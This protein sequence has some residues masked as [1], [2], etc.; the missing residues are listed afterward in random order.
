[1]RPTYLDYPISLKYHIFIINEGFTIT[2][3]FFPL[4]DNRFDTKFDTEFPDKLQTLFRFVKCWNLAKELLLTFAIE[5]DFQLC[6][7]L[8]NQILGEE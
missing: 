4:S 2:F 3:H 5:S 8:Q 7:T 1:M 6:I